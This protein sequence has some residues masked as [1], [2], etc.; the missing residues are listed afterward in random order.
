MKSKL[1]LCILLGILL[2]F[3]ITPLM[4]VQA[5][6][7]I[8][9]TER[10]TKVGIGFEEI[11]DDPIVREP[12][13]YQPATPKNIGQLPNTGEMLTSFIVLL[14]GLSVLIIFVGIANLK[15]VYYIRVLE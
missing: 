4:T 8:D 12:I 11:P 9:H 13:K 2:S 3:A 15:R 6:D 5:D 10:K 14:I 7:G 1:K